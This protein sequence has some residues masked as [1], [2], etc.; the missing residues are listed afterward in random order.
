MPRYV[1]ADKL[2]YNKIWIE[3]EKGTKSDVVV[4]AKEIDKKVINKEL[5]EVIYADWIEVR[6]FIHNGRFCIDNEGRYEKTGE[7]EYIS[8]NICSNCSKHEGIKTKYC[9]QCGAT[10]RL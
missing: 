4:F 9:P 3:S 2:H 5:K 8:R 7:H 10:M 1:D 6:G